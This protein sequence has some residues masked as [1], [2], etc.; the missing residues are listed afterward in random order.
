[1]ETPVTEFW[2]AAFI[3]KQAMWGFTPA[4]SAVTTKDLFLL[5]GLKCILIP[6]I[7]YG[8]NADVFR[9]YGMHVTGI[10]ISKTALDLAHSHYG[11]DMNIYHGSVADMPFDEKEYDGIFCYGLIHLF[12]APERKKLIRDCYNQLRPG[13]YM[14][15]VTIAKADSRFGSGT[16][17]DA[18]RFEQMKGVQLFFYDTDSVQREFGA[19][20]LVELAEID[21]PNTHADNQPPQKFLIVTCKK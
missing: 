19:Y 8:R 11:S 2:E 21:E 9:Q 4:L 17:V 14:V 10:E 1:M 5:H 13:G 7:G 3:D 20:G 15:F 16:K 6:G 12:D 18:D